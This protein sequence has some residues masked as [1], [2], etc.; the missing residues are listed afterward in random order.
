MT[1][2]SRHFGEE[3][4]ELLDGR[5]AP[6]QRTRLEEHLAACAECRQAQLDLVRA[7]RAVRAG[8]PAVG[9]PGDVVAGIAAALDHEDR[10]LLALRDSAFA[11]GPSRARRL[12]YALLATAAAVMAGLWLFASPDLPAAVAKD[13]AQYRSGQLSLQLETDDVQKMEGFFAA[14]GIAFRTR[15]FDLGMMGYRLEGGRV[16]SLSGRPSALFAY[17]GPGNK[18]LVCQMYEGSARELPRGGQEQRH[19]DFTFH[20]YRRD[21]KTLV[22]WEE[23]RVVCVLTGDFDAEEILQ[24]AFAKAMK[25]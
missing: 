13:Y 21:G 7:R 15:V 9:V 25:S 23:G 11:R 4:Q 10:K 24:L 20:I 6:A 5:L 3:I 2:Q 1:D 14:H 12:A 16:E 17:R 18:V 22:F 19:G 8:V